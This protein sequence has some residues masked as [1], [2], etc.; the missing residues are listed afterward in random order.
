MSVA[1]ELNSAISPA[2]EPGSD[3]EKKCLLYTLYFAFSV[4]APTLKLYLERLVIGVL[5]RFHQSLLKAPCKL[6]QFPFH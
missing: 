6:A 3:E 2:L 5:L 4:H 1:P